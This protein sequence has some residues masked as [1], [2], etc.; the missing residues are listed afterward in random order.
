MRQYLSVIFILSV[1]TVQAQM[2]PVLKNKRGIAIL[3]VQN[4][5]SI[6]FGA[7][8][9]L[10]YF[11]NLFNG[12]I[13]NGF[14]ATGYAAP[15]QMLSFKYMKTN[16]KAYRANFRFA[17]NNDVL[18]FNVKDM[19]PGADVN[20]VV[21]DQQRRNNSFIGLGF[22]IE[23]RKG[24]GR[25]Q[26][27]YGVEGLISYASGSSINYEYG[28]KLE[29]LDTGIIRVKKQKASTLFSIG[30][31]AFA[32]V[33]YFIAPKLSLGAEFG[34]GP[35]IGFGS[36]SEQTMEQYDFAKSETVSTVNTLSPINTS[37]N[38]DTDNYSGILK[39]MFY[40]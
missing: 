7:N 36:S 19:S 25:I 3:P 1:V 40:F 31:R 29:N 14:P 37:F 2:S 23:K 34:Y 18:S 4:E 30:L 13:N 22:G 35:R 8:P 15:N 28:N 17:F 16:N 6:G 20:A 5:F 32:G 24:Q 12:N 39:L 9:V 33:E 10:N 11:G 38:L 27:I 26:G 21:T